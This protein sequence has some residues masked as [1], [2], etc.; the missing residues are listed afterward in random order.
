MQGDFSRLQVHGESSADHSSMANLYRSSPKD[1]L[2]M[3][4][5]SHEIN[6]VVIVLTLY[7]LIH[8]L[9]IRGETLVDT[10]P[11]K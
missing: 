7:A 3:D 10:Q 9:R 8:L 2:V 1:S 11:F 5:M 4:S 6:T